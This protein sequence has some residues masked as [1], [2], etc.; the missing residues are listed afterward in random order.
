MEESTPAAPTAQ[1]EPTAKAAPAAKKDLRQSTLPGIE[2]IEPAEEP[3]EQEAPV[4]QEPA[5]PASEE[6]TFPRISAPDEDPREELWEK[7]DTM[8]PPDASAEAQ[9][10]FYDDRHMD[11]DEDDHLYEGDDTMPSQYYRNE[12]NDPEP[13]PG[14]TGEFSEDFPDPMD[15]ELQEEKEDQNTPLVPPPFEQLDRYGFFLG[16]YMTIKLI[17]TSPRLFFSVMPV[18]GGLAKPLTFTILITMIQGFVQYF[19]SM[20]GLSTSV[21]PDGADAMA[22]VSQTLAPIVM[23]LFMP[24]LIAAGQFFITAVY[25]LLLKLMR[26]DNSGFEG[27]FRALAYANAPIIVGIFPMPMPEIELGWMFCAAIWGLFL[28]ITGLRYIHKTS[29]AKV[30]PVCLIPLLLAMIAG[31]M[32]FQSSMPTI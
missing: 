31:L 30:I 12:D 23:L 6:R 24:A 1:P 32:V 28:T 3:A 10:E 29:Y 17:L 14:W 8:T 7:L 9:E 13:V 19:W 18:G 27:T 2:P 25:H 4:V 22:G 26:A 11:R 15:D 21:G 5:A 16:L 20:V